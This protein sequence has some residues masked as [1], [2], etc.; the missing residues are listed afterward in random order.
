MRHQRGFGMIEIIVVVALV[1]AAGGLGYQQWH[2]H[3]DGK[4]NADI[5]VVERQDL[6]GSVPAVSDINIDSDLDAAANALDQLDFDV[7]LNQSLQL[8]NDAQLR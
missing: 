5:Q 1:V 6:T 8:G 7:S 2:L 3:Q 4:L